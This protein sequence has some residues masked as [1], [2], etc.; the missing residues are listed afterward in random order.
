MT[1]AGVHAVIA[2]TLRRADALAAG[3]AEGLTAL[4]PPPRATAQP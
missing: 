1:A 2:A 3:D 4:L